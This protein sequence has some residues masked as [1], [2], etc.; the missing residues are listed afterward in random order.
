MDMVDVMLVLLTPT[1]PHINYI[2]IETNIMDGFSLIRVLTQQPMWHRISV[3]I[4]QLVLWVV[5]NLVLLMVMEMLA[6]V[7]GPLKSTHRNLI[8]VLIV[9]ILCHIGVDIIHS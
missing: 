8:V 4:I 7:L 2:F 1:S 9:E 3:G 6:W 5:F